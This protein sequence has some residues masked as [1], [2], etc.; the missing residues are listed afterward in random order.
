[1]H[2]AFDIYTASDHLPRSLFDKK[3]GP[4]YDVAE[5]AFQAAASTHKPRWDWLE[6]K[7]TVRDLKEGRC[8]TNG[9][10][11]A[12][13][14]PF[15]SELDRAVKGKADS[16][17]VGRPELPIFGLAMVGGGQVFGKAHLYGKC[18]DSRRG[19]AAANHAL[20]LSLGVAGL[21]TRG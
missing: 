19:G 2:S 4:S 5:T 8:G 13:P 21:G 10:S 3:S 20:R 14:G 16:D 18:P 6:E 15:G 7:V 9:G 12:Y 11:S 1:M 17:L